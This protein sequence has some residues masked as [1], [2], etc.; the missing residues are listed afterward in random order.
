MYRLIEKERR[1]ACYDC[2]SIVQSAFLLLNVQS[3]TPLG[4]GQLI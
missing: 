3:W 4:I 1:G 2:Q